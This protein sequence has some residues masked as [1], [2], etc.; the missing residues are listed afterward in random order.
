MTRAPLPLITVTSPAISMT[1]GVKHLAA[2][3]PG[4]G[5]QGH[6]R[7]WSEGP[8]RRELVGNVSLAVLPTERPD[9]W[10]V[11]GRG[12]LALAVLVETIAAGG[13]RADDRPAERRYPRDSTAG[14]T[15]RW[16][17]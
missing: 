1:V 5:H 12:E 16:S 3:G 13:L 6:P 17:G 9:T 8:A 2:G 7:G 15:S 4:Q 11:Q 10:E 14:C